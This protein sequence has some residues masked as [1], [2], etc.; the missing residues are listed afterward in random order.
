MAVVV[1]KIQGNHVE[2]YYDNLSDLDNISSYV[3]GEV[4]KGSVA[5]N[6]NG[7][8]AIYDGTDWNVIGE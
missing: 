2:A 8:V 3:P 4:E 5:Y 7:D 1:K 6:A